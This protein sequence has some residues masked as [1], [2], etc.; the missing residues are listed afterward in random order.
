MLSIQHD[1][2]CSFRTK[3]RTLKS[4]RNKFLSF[5][6]KNKWCHCQSRTSNSKESPKIVSLSNNRGCII[7]IMAGNILLSESNLRDKR[8]PLSHALWIQG[9]Q[10]RWRSWGRWRGEDEAEAAGSKVWQ[11]LA[12]SSHLIPPAALQCFKV[13][14]LPK[15]ISTP[16]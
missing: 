1:F 12:A 15:P 10:G 7:F 3:P 9:M 14:C 2:L 8:T 13:F 4:F 6:T 11:V 16:Y 5:L